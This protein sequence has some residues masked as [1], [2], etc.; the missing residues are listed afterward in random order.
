MKS[1]LL[2]FMQFFIIFLMLLPLGEVSSS[3]YIGGA[4]LLLG[5]LIGLAAL[6][7]NRVGNFNVRPDIRENCV[8]ITSGIYAFIRHPM[9]SSVLLMM[10]GILIIY[11]IVY[12]AVLYGAL[13]VTLLVKMFYEEKLWHCESQEYKIYS[14]NTKRLI[15]YLF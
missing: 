3:L 7:A 13:V 2:V 12:E 5:G 9:Y 1:Y 6:Y 11:P 4:V 10:L 15:P 14:E 8:L